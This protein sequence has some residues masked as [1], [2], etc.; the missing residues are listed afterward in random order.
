MK[1]YLLMIALCSSIPAISAEKT[2]EEITPSYE[3]MEQYIQENVPVVWEEACG[4]KE[5]N[6]KNFITSQYQRFCKDFN[7]SSASF[8][9]A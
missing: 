4:M 3:E 6:K 8:N 2:S 1:K 5:S 7:A 9:D